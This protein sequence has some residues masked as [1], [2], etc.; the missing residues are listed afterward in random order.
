MWI[1][2]GL[3]R[4]RQ[5]ADASLPHAR[6]PTGRLGSCP[7]NPSNAKLLSEISAAVTR[8]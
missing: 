3:P 7:A 5:F 8:E 4:I 1:R 6:L 2:N